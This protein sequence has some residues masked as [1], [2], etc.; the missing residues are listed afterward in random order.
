[1]P[2]GDR[3]QIPERQEFAEYDA[4]STG[5]PTRDTSTSQRRRGKGREVPVWDEGIYKCC[6]NSL[7]FYDNVVVQ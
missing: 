2:I 6:C 4:W 5:V 1:M 3:E 7:S